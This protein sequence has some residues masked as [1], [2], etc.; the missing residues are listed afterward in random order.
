ML[1]P[2]TTPVDQQGRPLP[3]SQQDYDPRTDPWRADNHA[4][5]DSELPTVL[6]PLMIYMPTTFSDTECF[7][8]FCFSL[9]I[10]IDHHLRMLVSPETSDRHNLSHPPQR[11]T[12]LCPQ[13]FFWLNNFDYTWT[14]PV[15][16][17]FSDFLTLPLHDTTPFSIRPL[18]ISDSSMPV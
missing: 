5:A 16:G 15:F 8:W 2:P 1:H 11:K 18:T 4:A 17:F 7:S 9:M 13:L 14:Q 12:S 3:Q 10:Y 6:Y